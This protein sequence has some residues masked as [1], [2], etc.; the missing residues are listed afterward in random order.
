MFLY[1]QPF[2]VI[3]LHMK[4]R[5]PPTV[6]ISC[7]LGFFGNIAN[8]GNVI[9]DYSGTAASWTVPADVTAVTFVLTAA[10]GG[11]GFSDGGIWCYGGQGAKISGTIKVSGGQVLKLFVGGTGVGRAGGF[12]GGGTGGIYW[13]YGSGGGGATDIRIGGT[14]L[15]NRVIVAGGGGGGVPVSPRLFG[16]YVGIAAQSG[17]ETNGQ[18]GIGSSGQ[19]GGGG[20]GFYGGRTSDAN[21]YSN[22]GGSSFYSPEL[23]SSVTASSGG[24]GD[25]YG[26]NG[27]IVI[28][29]S[30][31]PLLTWKNTYFLSV[32]N[33]GDS[34]DTFDYEGDGFSNLVEYALGGD[35][36]VP[37]AT[38]I[39]PVVEI[40][41][42][43]I[44]ISFK[45]DAAKT[46]ISYIV[47]ASPDLS[48]GSWVDIAK[49][50]GGAPIEPISS[51][52]AVLDSR[53]GARMV[54]VTDSTFIPIGGKRFL[55]VKIVNPA[56]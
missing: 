14:D 56:S 40:S 18:L 3:F 48:A 16:G 8:G 42:N 49:S 7:L 27:Q 6:L 39:A 33:T 37:D 1:C 51:L 47:Q 9:F 26:P 34:A 36:K 23:T 31:I 29:Y 38:T 44:Q 5:I 4:N 24:V 41:E 12:N 17:T 52:S 22:G 11:N 28:T 55:R 25:T 13:P 30:A 10:T 53:L 21:N 54:T 20:G 46:D 19:Y 15:S 43:Q 45:C 32:D 35:P 2:V 50:T